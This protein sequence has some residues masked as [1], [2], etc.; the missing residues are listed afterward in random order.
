MALNENNI[1]EDITI[2][3]IVGKYGLNSPTVLIIG[4]TSIGSDSPVITLVKSDGHYSM[5][6]KTFNMATI[7][8]SNGHYKAFAGRDKSVN[9]NS[10]ITFN[11][12]HTIQLVKTTQEF[13]NTEFDVTDNTLK[14]V[15]DTYMPIF[16]MIFKVS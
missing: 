1:K 7:A 6:S 16:I 11:N 10:N 2:N 5:E 3:N 12:N 14:I 4:T 8:I 15:V 13:G 9:N